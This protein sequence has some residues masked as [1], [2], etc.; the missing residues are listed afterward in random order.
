MKLILLLLGFMLMTSLVIAQPVYEKIDETTFKKMETI[1]ETEETVY[2]ITSLT[3]D[4]ARLI[5][6]FKARKAEFA[7][8]EEELKARL[9]EIEALILKAEELGI[10]AY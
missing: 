3:E 4:K 6:E 10:V 2:S 7:K 5:E 1:T 9:A 8:Q